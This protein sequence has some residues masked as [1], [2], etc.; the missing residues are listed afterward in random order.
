LAEL[1]V[2]YADYAVWQREWLE[3][4]VFGEQMEYWRREGVK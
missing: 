4:S 2:Q 1:A 3:R